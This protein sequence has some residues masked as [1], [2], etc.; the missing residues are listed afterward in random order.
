MTRSPL[1]GLATFTFAVVTVVSVTEFADVVV[2]VRLPGMK[3]RAT[4]SVGP[5]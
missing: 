3:P 4:D 5:P 2:V 1:R